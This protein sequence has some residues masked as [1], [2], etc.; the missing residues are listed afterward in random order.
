MMGGL[1]TSAAERSPDS[2][3][4]VAGDSRITWQALDARVSA[5]AAGL[6]ELPTGAGESL[7]V[8]LPNCPEFVVA[9]FAAAR[10]GMRFLPLNP[11]LKSGEMRRFFEECRARFVITSQPRLAI[12]QEAI[13]GLGL[14]AELI[15]T[16]GKAANA[17]PFSSLERGGTLGALPSHEGE[18]LIQYSSGS[19]GGLKQVRRSQQNLVSEAMNFTSSTA[20]NARDRILCLVP[21]HHAHGLGNGLLA[22]TFSGA[23]LILDSLDGPAPS[24]SR[25]EQILRLIER[26]QV[27][28]FPGVPYLFD[29]LARTPDTVE[30]DLSSLRLCF[31]AGNTL[32]ESVFQAFLQRFGTPV[33]QLYG[34]TEA[35]S[36]AMNLDTDPRSTADSV[37]RP[38]GTV[39][40][41]IAGEAGSELPAGTAGEIAIQSP[42][43][44]PGYIGAPPADQAA[45][46]DG[47]FFTGDLGKT[48]EAG[49]IYITGRKRRFLDSGGHKVDPAEIEDLLRT[50]PLVQD[51]VVVGVDLPGAGEVVKAV[52]VPRGECTAQ[53][54]IAYC[55]GRLADFKVP[56]FVEFVAE[57][58]R[59]PLGKIVRAPLLKPP[60]A[61]QRRVLTVREAET[62]ARQALGEVLGMEPAGI[63]RNRP[64][65]DYGAD[66]AKAVRLSIALGRSLGTAVPATLI[67]SRPTLAA[68]AEYL[69]A[70]VSD[71]ESATS[72]ERPSASGSIAI[73]GIG[74][75]FPGQADG[76]GAFW[77]LLRDGTDATSEIPPGRWNID[78]YFDP[79]P[80]KPGCMSTRRGGFLD[81]VDRFDAAFFGI[82][83]REAMYMDPQQRILL[84]VAWEALENAGQTQRM[85]AHSRTEVLIG[86]SNSDYSRLL[87][88]HPISERFMETGNRDCF[89][90]GRISYMLD[91]RGPSIALD[92]VCSSS[93]VA[94][95]LACRSLRMSDCDM[96]LA[97]GVNLM[98][99][100]ETMVLASQWGMLAPDGRC[101][102]F[103]ARADGFARSE[104]CGV[105]VLKRLEDAQAA[106]DPIVA[107]I[108]GSAANQDGRS[109]GL[110]A[111]N[112]RAQEAV[113][114]QA[115]TNAGV[116][117]GEVEFVETHG[118]GTALGDP[119]EVEA[120]AAV[121]GGEAA[122]PCLLGAVKTNIGHTEAVAGVAGLIKAALALQ[123]EEIPANLHFETLNPNIMLAGTRLEL[124]GNPRPWPRRDRPR[125]AAVSSFG[126]S[127]TNV[128]MVLEEAPALR[129]AGLAG[130][131]GE[132]ASADPAGPFLLPVSARSPDALRE[133]AGRYA[134]WLEGPTAG[135]PQDVC[136]SAG[137]RR[138][139][140]RYRVAVAGD[141]TAELA[142]ALRRLEEMRQPAGVGKL[143][144][145]PPMQANESLAVAQAV[146]PANYISSHLLTDVVATG[147][148]RAAEPGAVFLF[149][150]QGG[151]WDGMGRD[152]YQ[153]E[154]VFRRS[155]DQCAEAFRGEV[156]WDLAERVRT[157]AS[158]QNIDQVQPALFA[159]SLGLSALW[160]SWGI[161][162][163][164]VVGHSLGEVAAAHVA[165][166]LSL[167]DAA[168]VICR[169]SRLLSRL[170]GSGAMATV[171]L[172]LAETVDAVAPYAGEVAVAVSNSPRWTVVSGAASAVDEVL[173]NLTERGVYCRR[174][175]VDVA[176][177]SPQVDGLRAELSAA[178]QGIE[179]RPSQVPI[180]ST[181]TA[182][183]IRGEEMEAEYWLR[184][185]R[186]PV[187]FWDVIQQLLTSGYTRFVELGPHPVLVTAVEEA[188]AH[189]R[190]A[191]VAI[192][193][194]RRGES[195]RATMLGNLAVLYRDGCEVAWR[196]VNGEGRFVDL[197]VYPWQRERY[198]VEPARQRPRHPNRQGLL[199]ERSSVAGE[200]RAYIWD[201][202]WDAEELG[203]LLGHRVAGLVVLPAAA[204]VEM[205]LEAARQFWGAGEYEL[206]ELVW[207]A[208]L[209]PARAPRV[210]FAMEEDEAGS[211]RFTLHSRG[212]EDEEWQKHA[213]GRLASRAQ[214]R[215]GREI[216]NELAEARLRCPEPWTGAQF[217]ERMK[218]NGLEYGAAFQGVQSVWRGAGEAI[219]QVDA[220]AEVRQ[221]RQRYRLHPALLDA[222]L[223]VLSAAG[224]DVP[225]VP[226][227][228]GRVAIAGNLEGS[229]SVWAQWREDVGAVRVIAEDGT[230]AAEIEDIRMALLPGADPDQEWLHEVRWQ[231]S[232]LKPT[233][234]AVTGRFLIL[235]ESGGLATELAASLQNRGAACVVAGTDRWR[236]AL[237]ESGGF[238]A[239]VWLTDGE[240]R[241][242]QRGLELVQRLALAGQRDCPRLCI[243]TR[244]T[245]PAGPGQVR[246]E[247]A[248][249]WGFGRSACYEH[250]ELRTTL[251]DLAAEPFPG[252]TAELAAEIASGSEEDQVALRPDGRRV[253]RLARACWEEADGA[254]ALAP[255][256]GRA[257]RLEAEKPGSLDGVVWRAIGRHRPRQGEVEVEVAAAGLSF[258]DA[259]TA[260][261]R[262]PGQPPRGALLGREFAGRIVAVGGGVESLAVGDAVLGCAEGAVATHLVV[263]AGSLVRKP[264]QLGWE[265]AATL[266]V[267]FTSAWYALVELARLQAGER[268]LIHS[269]A[270]G[271]GRA[272]LSIARWL[273]AEA[274]VTAG[275]PERREWLRRQPGVRRV[276][277][278]RTTEF[279]AQ[280]LA[281]TGG[282]GVHVVLNSLAGEGMRKSLEA[283]ARWGRFVELGKRDLW[284]R[285]RLETAPFRKSLSYFAV[286]MAALA[287]ERPGK[288]QQLLAT[289]VGHVAAGDWDCLDVEAVEPAAA[290]AAVWRMVEGRQEKKLAVRLHAVADLPIAPRKGIGEEGTYLVTG[291]L[292]G[293]GL[294]VAE[295]LAGQG[296]RHLA[297]VGRT[298]PGE[299][300]IATIARLRA[301]GTQVAVYQCD[302]GDAAS[303]QGI[304]SEIEAGPAPLRGVI[305]AAAVLQDGALAGMAPEAFERVLRPKVAGAWN[306]HQ[307]TLSLGLDFFA[308]MSSVASVMGSPGQANYA[309]ANAWLDTFAHWRRQAGLV[310]T[311]I[312]WGPWAEV[313]LAAARENRGARLGERGMQSIPPE[314]GLRILG[315]LLWEDRVQTAVMKLNLR[316]WCQY[317][318]KVATPSWAELGVEAP[319]PAGALREVLTAADLPDRQPLMERHVRQQI[320]RVLRLDAARVPAAASFASLGFDSL[321]AIELR[322]RLE[323]SLGVLLPATLIWAHPSAAALS[324]HLMRRMGFLPAAETA[325]P[326]ARIHSEA[327]GPAWDPSCVEEIAGL[328]EAQVRKLLSQ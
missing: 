139:H 298:A 227:R 28:V 87:A 13:A 163:A 291:G 233:S 276:M 47:W 166:A 257:F 40:V 300:Q 190:V 154:A 244:G 245:Q 107:V 64:L 37:G 277:D 32:S 279:A 303:V 149:P 52:V 110:T 208:F 179:P 250:S 317:Y 150:G 204:V 120:L 219:A 102:T 85:A 83:P 74:C 39:R 308:L 309:A 256:G 271:T 218:R 186:Q 17:R 131:G 115:L 104:G 94:V 70:R 268:V 301:A 89:T 320:A 169:R 220:T 75:R 292:G 206:R 289:V 26:E 103:D 230:L 54:L 175:N 132:T 315:R 56:R 223:Q 319:P 297:L 119:I 197:P 171:E 1:L 165:G 76:A 296:A 198:W 172:S 306:L 105:V 287:A 290:Q 79:D 123:H 82:S 252:E 286:D 170:K 15:V 284:E 21:L 18:F 51:A 201:G 264:E 269:A 7:A 62:L 311:S 323:S 246:L 73:V 240:D 19:M 226:V 242:C 66:S 237:A 314:Q 217:Y 288:M 112:G 243:V 92:T 16:A 182:A 31:S 67:W 228:A 304:V 255:A 146:P 183:P 23:T 41:Q 261:A 192:G 278:S 168:R 50:H 36:I 43:L 140:H 251:V 307:S 95:Y 302:V 48:D 187:R 158:W 68:V 196:A 313:G 84:E 34:C 283:V 111:P 143:K 232:P 44:T 162:P 10:L 129:S 147:E 285:D 173:R 8:V 191:G 266:G 316:Q 161:E 202:D 122:G 248:E 11:L 185:L 100:P 4:L 55:G 63:D 318:P 321:T 46:R 3:A 35:G 215:A 209:E 121:Y 221:E 310:A 238:R 151:Q 305:H 155:I 24:V 241:V 118:S 231:R 53:D 20:V 270:T 203:S 42:A 328:T 127:G 178:L 60:A 274:W 134:G 322:N 214:A 299:A 90:A 174:V 88:D 108:R 136:Y 216:A 259:L 188:L 294:K 267:A 14:R 78:D 135:S 184:N 33:R 326:P 212:G 116:P 272:A 148:A 49:R 254:P 124:A 12:C 258:V 109:A 189:Q 153:W 156:D 2:L 239:V 69:A 93:L 263:P 210:Q 273:G 159:I 293:I 29:A 99:S 91:L 25:C 57:L 97:G 86:V 133:L 247:G 249:L 5:F 229:L 312:N 30:A 58:P 325:A 295:W 194:T 180:Y 72:A 6:A 160:R 80:A 128:H 130:P 45:F 262:Y 205:A 114:R 327:G 200:R 324:E 260:L 106:G 137:E 126:W 225:R 213:A 22:A 167:A 77:R 61:S 280:I 98:L 177:H 141:T 282:E 144:H 138:T 235:G 81:A 176:S 145:A 65:M 211:A 96:A 59:S 193:S 265:Q 222:C 275:T 224:P 281:E 142:R 117:A 157:G 38:L 152:L 125:Y 71:A 236:E 199:G 253:A 9:F 27:T 195:E 164:V 181:V 234:D 207:S 101:K 113:L